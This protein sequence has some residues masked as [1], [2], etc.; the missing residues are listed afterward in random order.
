MASRAATLRTAN[1]PRQPATH[2]P[3]A[4]QR[5]RGAAAQPQ[6]NEGE[7]FNISEFDEDGEEGDSS[8][9]SQVP[10]N[11][12]TR[13][14]TPSVQAIE[15]MAKGKSSS[16]AKDLHHFFVLEDVQVEPGKI[17]KKKVCILCKPH[18]PTGKTWHY[19]T[20]TGGFNLRKHLQRL[21]LEEWVQ[22]CNENQFDKH[23]E[24]V[25]K[26][27]QA[28]RPQV[29]FTQK[30]FVQHLLEFIVADDQSINVIECPEFRKLLLFLCEKLLDKDIPRR[31]KVR[32]AIV[33]AW[34]EYFCELKEQLACGHWTVD[35]A[36]ANTTFMTS[37]KAGLAD[38]GTGI[39]FDPVDRRIMCF[40]HVISIA[41]G[42]VIQAVSAANYS[43]D[44]DEYDF[45]C[46]TDTD[47][48]DV[49][50]LCRKTVRVLRA[51]GQRMDRFHETI[52]TGNDKGW[53]SDAK[54]N[55][56]QLPKL[57]FILD[58][59]EHFLS[60][61]VNKDLKHLL[62]NAE[63][64]SRLEDFACILECP[65]IV[66]QSMSAEKTP[67]LATSMVH[68]E[69]F[70]TN[71]E[72]IGNS[73]PDLRQ[74]TDIGLNWATKY[75]R[76]MDNSKAYLVSQL[77]DPRIRFKYIEKHWEPRY[78]MKAKE[79]IKDLMRKYRQRLSGINPVPTPGTPASARASKKGMYRVAQKYQLSDML[80]FGGT[81]S[82]APRREMSVAEEY[83]KYFDGTISLPST[84]PL[85][86][87]DGRDTEFPTLFSI[88]VDYLPIQA[89][90]VPCERVFSSAAETDTKRRNRIHP[91]LMEALQMYKFGLKSH[92][93]DFMRG[94]LTSEE[95]MLEGPD[96]EP[97]HLANISSPMADQGDV[98][99]M[100]SAIDITDSEDVVE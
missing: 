53:F 9:L 85:Q 19:A 64:W 28:V 31:T 96:D 63:E 49:I 7:E 57:Q 20:G 94:L 35:N 89:S 12:A 62:M 47:L 17:Q 77:L 22:F 71:W 40:P 69:M 100:L 10:S 18:P 76:R 59:L 66:L 87:W 92:R 43:A 83:S 81:L 51:S 68:F 55:T 21:H 58:P 80:E 24:R 61:P 74:F 29:P 56:V 1:P 86:F 27:S 6:R 5:R 16:E 65:H 73:N 70:M 36:E 97:D 26:R 98:D 37:L 50:A 8:S 60:S 45:D 15:P 2:Q 67:M 52:D 34:Q 48:R 46:D 75:Y 14:S 11:A 99:A 82:T 25:G 41:T 13:C 79:V 54:G 72:T 32:S 4:R 3:P 30:A 93:L 90:A 23:L 91:S 95:E 88:A 38:L 42:H 33:H 44:P 39:E 78:I 84:D